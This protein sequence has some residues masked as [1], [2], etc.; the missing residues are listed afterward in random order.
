M[1]K[2][3]KNIA[4]YYLHKNKNNVTRKIYDNQIKSRLENINSIIIDKDK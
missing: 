4:R 1:K 3:V 2:L